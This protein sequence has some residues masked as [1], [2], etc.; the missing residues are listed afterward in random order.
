MYQSIY[1]LTHS[2]D[3]SEKIR[4]EINVKWK[5]LEEADILSAMVARCNSVEILKDEVESS[6]LG[7]L[8]MVFFTLRSIAEIQSE[9]QFK[10]KKDVDWLKKWISSSND[11]YYTHL[12]HITELSSH[13]QAMLLEIRRRKRYDV[14]LNQWIISTKKRLL[15]MNVAE[16]QHR[17]TFMRQCGIYLPACFFKLYP[18]LKE[19]PPL[20]SLDGLLDSSDLPTLEEAVIGEEDSANPSSFSQ[21]SDSAS[22]PVVTEN[23]VAV[24]AEDTRITE[25]QD[26]IRI[27]EKQIID[28]NVSHSSASQSDTVST[29][30]KILLKSLCQPDIAELI[31]D[32]P[33]RSPE[34]HSSLL[35]S[36]SADVPLEQL[37]KETLDKVESVLNH[38]RVKEKYPVITFMDFHV[39]AVALFMPAFVSSFS[40]SLVCSPMFL[41]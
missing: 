4:S 29:T 8:K 5:S 26:R 41:G 12:F 38:L 11:G 3:G 9:I 14:E 36:D 17:E 39:G 40:D 15:E 33:S 20:F 19:K 27:L 7:T 16:V 34:G 37:E 1:N 24:L 28:M 10:L 21:V 18:S 23:Q 25:L 13:Y 35:N 32:P 6:R 2:A 22:V 30:L 31:N